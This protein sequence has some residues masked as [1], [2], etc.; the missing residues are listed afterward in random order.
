[1]PRLALGGAAAAA[2][3]V[4]LAV[5]LSGGPA[6]PTVAD[7]ARLAV[8]PPSGPAPMRLDDS[9]AKLTERVDG[10]VF[11][12]LRRSHGWRPVGVRHDRVD[13]RDASVVYYA[14]DGKRIGYAI[15]AGAGLPAPSGSRATLRRGVS[16]RTLKVDGRPVVTWRRLGHTCVLTGSA[17]RSELLRLASWQGGGTLRY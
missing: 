12:D 13:G 7:A 17:S 14:S 5:V 4:V 6:G 11:P 1:M 2:T 15:L 16:Y 10:V 8:E 3:A 9:R